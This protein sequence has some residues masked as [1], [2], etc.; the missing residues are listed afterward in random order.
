MPVGLGTPSACTQEDEVNRLYVVGLVAL[1]AACTG[2]DAAPVPAES[3]VATG[4]DAAWSAR[5]GSGVGVHVQPAMHPLHP[6][7][8]L[9][10]ITTDAAGAEREVRS[11]DLVSPSMPLHGVLRFPVEKGGPG[12]YLVGVRFPME[13]HWTLYVNLDDGLDAAEFHFEVAPSEA[14]GHHSHHMAGVAG[15]DA[16]PH[17][18]P[19]AH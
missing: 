2:S 6:G 17:P 7:D 19:H 9:F 18:H 11:V 8:M 4:A 13:G 14:G 5:S 1:A 12:L 16:E 3:A 15:H 10:R